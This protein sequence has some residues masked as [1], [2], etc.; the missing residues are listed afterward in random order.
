[1]CF[2]RRVRGK[3]SP[4][5]AEA[6]GRFFFGNP[7]LVGVRRTKQNIDVPRGVG[8]AP[9]RVTEGEQG[10]YGRDGTLQKLRSEGLMAFED[11][12]AIGQ[13]EF[14]PRSPHFGVGSADSDK[15]R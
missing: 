9:T 7:D 11:A 4:A 14:L 15:P 13:H 2:L 6:E 1:M 5:R 12:G 3:I 10:K 8:N